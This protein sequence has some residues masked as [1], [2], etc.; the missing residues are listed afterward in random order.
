MRSIALKPTVWIA[1]AKEVGDELRLMELMSVQSLRGEGACFDRLVQFLASADFEVAAI[2]APFA[3]PLR[4]M[5]KGR[6]SELLHQVKLLPDASD[7]SFPRGATIVELGEAVSP[8]I[9]AKPLRKTE[10]YWASKG[11]NTRSTMWCGP[12]GGAAMTA[13]CLRLIERSGLSAWPWQT[14]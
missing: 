2:D 7:R 12:R 13:A 6:H 4:H 9:E 8:K 1:V 3:L 14:K 10:Q 11:V 5:P